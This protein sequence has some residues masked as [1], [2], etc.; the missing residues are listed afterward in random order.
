MQH[1][2]EMPFGARLRPEGGAQFRLW[3]PAAR[4][5]RLVLRHPTKDPE[6]LDAH[7]LTDGW[8]SVVAPGA[9]AGDL[10]QWEI[11]GELRVPDPASRFN[12]EGPH[13]PCQ[14]FDPAKFDWDTAWSGRPWHEAVIYEL[15]VGCFTPAGTYA[16]A[17]AQLPALAQLGITA[18]QLMPLN[19]FPGRFGWGY[20]GVLPYAPHAPYG[21]P[22][23]L[24]RFIQTAH[25][26]N[27]MVFLDVVY[28]H[29]GPDGNYL[30]RYAP[31]FFTDT[32]KTAWGPAVNFDA[33]G[34]ETVREFFIHNALYWLQEYRFD[35]LRFDAVHAMLDNSRPDILEAISTRVREALPDR[36][37]HLVLENDSNDARRLAAPRTPGRYEGQW[38]G[39]FHHTLHVLLTDEH[40]G[41]YAEYDRPL[42]QL[43]RC[44]THGFARQGG[45]HNS[46]HAAPRQAAEGSVPLSTTVNF[47]QNHDQ[48]GNRA[49]GE[50]LTQLADDASL[51]LAT[52]VCLLSPTPPLLFM[53]EEF[54][55]TT[56][57][58]YFADWSGELR[59]AV[60]QGRRREFEH[61]P[62]Y[63]EAARRGDLPDPCSIAT[64][65]RSKLDWVS[66]Q[67][68]AHRE[69]RKL[70]AELLAL[71]AR[72]I[73]P[74]LPGLRTGAHSAEIG[75][76]GA[77]R[78]RWRF[79]GNAALEMLIN[80]QHRSCRLEQRSQPRGMD[81]AS[82]LYSLGDV[83]ADSLS[84]W[85]GRWYW[86]HEVS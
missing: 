47:L 50:R 32:H 74:Q 76:D 67:A 6:I 25:R 38:N 66:A 13:G 21:S 34:S 15:H 53:G 86:G 16:A 85:A 24:K 29:F 41:Y 44:L 71:R 30:S 2:H 7:A 84:P 12:P 9:A 79:E 10:Y 56:P 75:S 35:G 31:Q 64:F 45:P 65:E 55:A 4:S 14:L 59:E 40:D 48:I 22:Q 63:A 62:R 69:W 11:D 28:N 83:V 61:F 23:D 54:G 1:V 78:V 5:A 20:D 8:Y 42:E 60:Q 33:P 70:Y 37:I 36:H 27:M 73:T 80:P 46:E 81:D 82:L 39:D 77:L 51:R 58:L 52:A 49:F 68:V 19:G 43:A 57:F 26:L 17:E 18:V 3:A 72:A